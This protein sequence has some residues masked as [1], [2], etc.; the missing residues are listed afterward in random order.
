MTI[1]ILQSEKSIRYSSE[2]YALL[3]LSFFSCEKDPGQYYEAEISFGSKSNFFHAAATS[4][5]QKNV[6]PS[7]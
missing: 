3:I 5:E 6:L 1:I 4:S 2:S 7:Y